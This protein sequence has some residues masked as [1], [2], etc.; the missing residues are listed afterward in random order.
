MR[1]ERCDAVVS[2]GSA[3]ASATVSFGS[4]GSFGGAGEASAPGNAHDSARSRLPQQRIELRGGERGPLRPH[5]GGRGGDDGRAEARPAVRGR[6]ARVVLERRVDLDVGAGREHVDP[7]PVRGERRTRA[8]SRRSRRRR[9]RGGRPPGRSS[10]C[11]AAASLPAAATTRQPRRCAPAIAASSCGSRF[12]APRLSSMT[13]G[14]GGGGD[15]RRRLDASDRGRH[16]PDVEP[17]PG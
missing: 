8:R 15:A 10:G 13:P 9:G 16:V 2:G 1:S 17:G 11:P 14:H 7:R 5:P 3:A 4:R 6:P 12:V